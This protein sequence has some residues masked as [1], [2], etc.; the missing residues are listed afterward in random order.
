MVAALIGISL[1]VRGAW[2]AAASWR[3]TRRVT[4]DWLRHGRLLAVSDVGMPVL[5]IE[6]A[7]PTVTVVGFSHPVMFIAERVLRE[8]SDAEVRAM[9]LHECAHVSQRDNFKRFMLRA[10]PDFLRAGGPLDRAW[11]GAA[12]E[13]ADATA[14]ARD[15]G[16]ALA[17][18]QA[19][20]RVAR[21]APRVSTPDLASAF[22]L[23]G[24]VESRVRRLIDPNSAPDITR[25]LGCV[26]LCTLF[27]AGAG[28]VLVAAP[29]IHQLMEQAVSILP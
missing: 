10:C 19:L 18:A 5:A 28:L 4:R 13:A 3:A 22:F 20:I 1:L 12:E 16:S 6:E 29:A 15:P 7:F 26:M 11:T 9:M 23:E 21:L 24:S 8:C 2:R 27:C 14:V 25:P 17:L